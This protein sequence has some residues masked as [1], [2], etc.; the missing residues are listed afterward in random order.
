MEGGPGSFGFGPELTGIPFDRKNLTVRLSDDD[1]RS[2]SVSRLLEDGPSGYS[3]LA[4]LSDGTLL[5]LYECG[6]VRRMYD[7][8][9]LRLARFNT[10]WI[11]A[12]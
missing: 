11:R 7:D 1:C 3:D 8:K 10:E 2:W 9:Y 5:C 4:V 6:I 12:G